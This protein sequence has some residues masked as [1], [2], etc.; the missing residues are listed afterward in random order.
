[1]SALPCDTNRHLLETGGRSQAES[2]E[3]T[4]TQ[5]Q[6]ANPHQRTYSSYSLTVKRK[7]R[8]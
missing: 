2:R 8:L 4:A 3:E 5:E 1:M 6:A 7:C